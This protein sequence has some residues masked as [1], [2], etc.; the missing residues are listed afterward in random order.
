[1]VFR[2]FSY[3][4]YPTDDQSEQMLQISSVC[5]AIWNAALEQRIFH[6]RNYQARTGDNL[7]YV[8]QA[9]ELTQLRKE[10]DWVKAVSQTAQQRT[11]KDLNTAFARFFTGKS[12]F[13]KWKAKGKHEAFSHVGREVSIEKINKR[14]S[15]VRLPKIGWL[16]FRRHRELQGSIIEASVVL[17]PLGWQISFGCKVDTQIADNGLSV[18]IDRGVAVPLMLS[19]GTSYALPESIDRLQRRYQRACRDFSRKRRGS[20][21][22]AKARRRVAVL[23]S[24]QAR[25]RKD[26][27]HK[28]TTDISR[29]YSHVVVER[30]RTKNMTARAHLKGVAQKRGLNRSILNIGWHQIETMLTYKCVSTTK[31]DPAYSSQTCATCGAVDKRSRKSQALFVCTACGHRDNA[32]RNAAVVIHHRGNTPSTEIGRLAVDEVRTSQAA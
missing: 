23:K 10:L 28:T 32:D 16:K 15:R 30:L 24:R 7:N 20:V 11:L 12:G 22:H 6:W 4:L 5:R 8:T 1:M 19:D 2:G 17:T 9:R 31:V 13:P 14:W 25:A 27:A 3:R 29:R 21:R 18:G 26:W